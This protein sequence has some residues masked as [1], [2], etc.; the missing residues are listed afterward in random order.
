MNYLS[1]FEATRVSRI[2]E[3]WKEQA[4]SP[5]TAYGR[6][7]TVTGVVKTYVQR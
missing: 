7:E 3:T 4:V 6:T 1:N 5:T 2:E